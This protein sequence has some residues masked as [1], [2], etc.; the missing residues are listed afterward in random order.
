MKFI[1]IILGIVFSFGS[2]AFADGYLSTEKNDK[3]RVQMIAPAKAKS[4]QYTGIS[5]KLSAR[6]IVD[7]TNMKVLGFQA[8]DVSHA[9]VPVQVY[10]C[11]GTTLATCNSTGMLY[12]LGGGIFAVGPDVKGVA[13]GIIS[14]ATATRKV[15]VH[16][17]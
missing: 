16:G 5:G 10:L 14:S 8:T 2:L 3:T 11:S 7:V 13:F 1:A 15:S 12:P 6:P 9:S 17:R 4:A